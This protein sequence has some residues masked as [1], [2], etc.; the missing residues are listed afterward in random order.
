MSCLMLFCGKSKILSNQ[1]QYEFSLQT[2]GALAKFKDTNQ[3]NI[4][5]FKCPADSRFFIRNSKLGFVNV[6]KIEYPYVSYSQ[7]DPV[8]FDGG[9]ISCVGTHCYNG[10]AV[11]V[12]VTQNGIPQIFRLY[13]NGEATYAQKCTGL[14]DSYAINNIFN[15]LNDNLTVNNYVYLGVTSSN[16]SNPYTATIS[17]TN[18]SGY[19]QWQ[20]PVKV[21]GVSKLS[22]NTDEKRVVGI[23]YVTSSMQSIVLD[24]AGSTVGH[25]PVYAGMFTDIRGFLGESLKTDSFSG[26]LCKSSTEVCSV[27]SESIE[28]IYNH[29]D[30]TKIKLLDPW[31]FFDGATG[32]I[33]RSLRKG[34]PTPLSTQRFV[35]VE[36]LGVSESDVYNLYL[37][38]TAAGEL[39]IV[40]PNKTTKVGSYDDGIYV[41][42]K[43]RSAIKRLYM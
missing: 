26:L 29:S 7:S 11:Y 6:N 5:N 14:T 37:G 3:D 13:N 35:D 40:K 8:S 36:L 9:V 24:Y 25:T 4:S 17:S 18:V 16:S 41:A 43:G 27:D 10:H 19:S 28:V 15:E 23:A 1:Y 12:L 39:Y 20:T 30:S 31:C 2:N 34:K 22:S 42:I 33:Y 32:Y 38:L 21:S